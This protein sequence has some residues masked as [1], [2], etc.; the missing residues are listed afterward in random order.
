M[1]FKD[2]LN[3]KFKTAHKFGSETVEIFEEPSKKEMREISKL[4]FNNIRFG[5]QDNKK[6]T[7]YMWSASFLHNEIKNKNEIKFDI[8]LTFGHKSLWLE[9]LGMRLFNWEQDI[10]NKKEIIEKIKKYFPKT[11]GIKFLDGTIDI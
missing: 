5:I 4:S 10:N 1:K 11:K 6:A 2:L 3:E 7:I 8:G 9:A